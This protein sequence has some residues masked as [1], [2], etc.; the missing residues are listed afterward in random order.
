[1]EKQ[2][3]GMAKQRG[4]LCGKSDWN[5]TEERTTD[6]QSFHTYERLISLPRTYAAII[7]IF[8]VFFL[9]LKHAASKDVK[10]HS[11]CTLQVYK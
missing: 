7:H 3:K 10:N 1:M 5:S 6:W 2:F 9:L 4:K 8:N 11:I